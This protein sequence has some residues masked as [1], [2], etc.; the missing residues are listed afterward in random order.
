M[1][2][3]LPN[4]LLLLIIQPALPP[5][6]TLSPK[7]AGRRQALL[8][9]LSRVNK[10]LCSLAKPLLLQSI[11]VGTPRQAELVSK[12]PKKLRV[13]VETVVF[14]ISTTSL[15]DID[16]YDEDDVP[17]LLVGTEA[18]DA[19]VALPKAKHAR[20]YDFG[21]LSTEHMTWQTRLD[22]DLSAKS[23]FI[24]LDSLFLSNCKLFFAGQGHVSPF[25]LAKLA[26]VGKTVL[27]NAGIDKLFRCDTLPALRVLRC[28]VFEYGEFGAWGT[29]SGALNIP[30]ELLTQME[31]LQL[32]SRHAHTFPA[33][34][35][36]STRMLVDLGTWSFYEDLRGAASKTRY[37]RLTS[38]HVDRW[39][40][41]AADVR[42]LHNLSAAFMHRDL[43]PDTVEPK[44]RDVAFALLDAVKQTPADIIWTGSDDHAFILPEFERYIKGRQ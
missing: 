15:D 38:V 39:S 27:M 1:L 44:N 29:S 30:A 6:D 7:T 23:P 16:P 13:R 34:S 26:F 36:K 33:I 35:S 5:H 22:F 41:P 17:D 20:F 28:A 40:S 24:D 18:L 42:D 4:E 9:S 12:L 32:N 43:L 2:D 31:A 10:R 21:D 11:V 3:K 19:L 37:I 8:T 14:H 25:A